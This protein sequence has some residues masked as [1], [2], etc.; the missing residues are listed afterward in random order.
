MLWTRAFYHYSYAVWVPIWSACIAWSRRS[1][2]GATPR[3]TDRSGLLLVAAGLALLALAQA[4]A[5][6]TLA[7]L[8]LPL[9][10][11]G[12]GTFALGPRAFRPLAFP[13]GFLMLMTPLPATAFPVLS[14]PLQEL[15]ASFTELVLRGS[16]IPAPREGLYFQVGTTTLHVAEGCSGLRFLLAMIVPGVALAWVIE[17]RLG[18]RLLTCVA[19]A[20]VAV[21]ANLARVSSTIALVNL[22]GAYVAVGTFHSLFGKTLY[23]SAVGLLLLGARALKKRRGPLAVNG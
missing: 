3:R 1:E 19:A 20:A 5:S 6:L 17:R 14:A 18:V 15:A 12:L 10:L 8:S 7:L 4:R 21:A 22:Y 23:L 9:S 16:G 13:V 2:L 11:T